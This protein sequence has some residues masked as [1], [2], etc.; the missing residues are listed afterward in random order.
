[1][2]RRPHPLRRRSWFGAIVLTGA[3]LPLL[4]GQNPSV[5]AE[6]EVRIEVLAIR[7][8]MQHDNIAP[9]LKELAKK[10]RAQ[11][12]FTGYTLE[13]RARGTAKIGQA[14]KAD[15]LADYAVHVLPRSRDNDRIELQVRVVKGPREK[16]KT[17]FT[18][19]CKRFQ[20]I[21][22]LALPGGQDQLIVGV[23]AR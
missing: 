5:P 10:L 22:G 18:M 20:F 23:S 4:G 8:T 3:L 12:K 16:L 6:D 14:M 15:L 17:S 1:M 21:G 13:R 7:A 2:N 9:D 11:F 19:N